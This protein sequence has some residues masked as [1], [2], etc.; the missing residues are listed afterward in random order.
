MQRTGEEKMRRKGKSA[1]RRSK[2]KKEKEKTPHDNFHETLF[3][4]GPDRNGG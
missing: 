2:R 4:A 3:V 1:V